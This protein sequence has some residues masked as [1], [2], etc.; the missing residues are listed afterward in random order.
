MEFVEILANPVR[1]HILANGRPNRRNVPSTNP[2]HW[3]PLHVTF[4]LRYLQLT[5]A[6]L[7][8]HSFNWNDCLMDVHLSPDSLL[9][10]FHEPP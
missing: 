7:P 3:H 9:S 6:V 4:L 10:S 8:E 2:P 5:L 1:R